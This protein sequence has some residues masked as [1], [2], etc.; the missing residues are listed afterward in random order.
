MGNNVGLGDSV[1]SELP[2]NWRTINTAGGCAAVTERTGRFYK[3]EVHAFGDTIRI[4]EGEDEVSAP[5]SVVLVVIDANNLN[6]T[7][8]ELRKELDV[9]REKLKRVEYE[10]RPG[11]YR[12]ARVTLSD[13]D[14]VDGCAIGDGFEVETE[15]FRRRGVAV[16]SEREA[17]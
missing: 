3:N 2:D 10:V 4:C 12:M 17:A 6:T 14:R 11:W 9:L 15:W 8:N 1:V 16:K 5:R 7:A 13:S